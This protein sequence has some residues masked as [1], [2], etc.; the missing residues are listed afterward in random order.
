[1]E[2]LEG[3]THCVLQ[4]IPG[5]PSS[6]GVGRQGR[7]ERTSLGWHSVGP[8]I[9]PL[10]PPMGKPPGPPTGKPPGLPMGKLPGL[11]MGIPPGPPKGKPPGPPIGKPPG[12]PMGKLPDPPMGLLP[13]PNWET[14]NNVMSN[15][16]TEI[17]LNGQILHA[18]RLSAH[19]NFKWSLN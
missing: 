10:G 12:P 19:A 13:G 14:S 7:V 6:H 17:D 2:F 11:P 4:N 1:M 8:T 15:A 16:K 5:Q 3:W 18:S 9:G